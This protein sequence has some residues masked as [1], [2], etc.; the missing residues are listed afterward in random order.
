[1]IHEGPDLTGERAL[2]S[3]GMVHRRIHGTQQMLVGDALWHGRH[4]HRVQPTQ[5][6]ELAVRGA[7]P[8]EHHGAELPLERHWSGRQWRRLGVD[9]PAPRAQGALQGAIKAEILPKLVKREDVAVA[10]GGIVD[11]IRRRIFSAP[12]CTVQPVD[13]GIALSRFERVQPT[14]TGN[15][16]QPRLARIVAERLD[17]LQVAA[18]AG[19]CDAREHGLQNRGRTA[20]D[21][22]G[23]S[24]SRVTAVKLQKPSWRR[25]DHLIFLC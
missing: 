16:A 24:L 10:E 5:A 7:E 12:G 11:D 13:E 8:V 2:D 17:N 18:T 15:D 20:E 6:P 4:C 1:M 23:Q 25:P 14:G 21:K 9:L 19:L 22:G 3:L